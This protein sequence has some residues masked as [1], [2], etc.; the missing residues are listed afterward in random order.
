MPTYYNSDS[1]RLTDKQLVKV[2][3]ETGWKETS[4]LRSAFAIVKRESGGAPA[5]Y[6]KNTNGSIDRGLF[7]INSVNLSYLGV[8]DPLKLYDPVY[9]SKMAFKLSRQGTNLSAWAVPNPDG[10]VS[11]WAAHIQAVNPT[12]YRSF[13]TKYETYQKQFDS[14]MD[15]TDFRKY[16]A[17]LQKNKYAGRGKFAIAIGA[18]LAALSFNKDQSE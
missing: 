18:A 11:G 17:S 14:L 1:T 13:Q 5:A 9:N 10:T 2:L 6:L 16:V 15:Q 3:I 8:S 7:Q 12:L 4:A